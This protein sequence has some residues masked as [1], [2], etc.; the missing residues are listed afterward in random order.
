MQNEQFSDWRIYRCRL[1]QIEKTQMDAE[2]PFPTSNFST[3]SQLS[4]VNYQLASRQRGVMIFLSYCWL[5]LGMNM[6]CSAF[7]GGSRCWSTPQ[8]EFCGYENSAFQAKKHPRRQKSIV[9]VAFNSPPLLC[10]KGN[11]F[12][13]RRSATYGQWHYYPPLPE[14]QNHCHCIE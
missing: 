14:R 10:L 4:I 2:F 11:N 7:Q 3:S 8:N 12:H 1:S 6:W 9:V 5:V 13:N